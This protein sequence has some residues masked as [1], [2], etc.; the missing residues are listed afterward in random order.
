MTSLVI[1]ESP[2]KRASIQ[3]YLDALY[4]K[5]Y[6]VVSSVGHVCD[7]SKKTLA[8]ILLPFRVSM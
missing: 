5:T 8:L 2:G 7:L 4:P 3:A 6:K 1:V